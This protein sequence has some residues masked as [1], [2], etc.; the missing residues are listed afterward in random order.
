MYT[1]NVKD[2]VDKILS[3]ITYSDKKKVDKL[4]ELSAT[5][6]AQTGIDSSKKEIEETRKNVRIIY[7]AIKFVDSEL[8]TLLMRVQDTK[9]G[10]K[11]TK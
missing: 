2:E 10:F 5:L 4:L 6:W 8:G 7:R 9:D 1:G 3:F 11:E